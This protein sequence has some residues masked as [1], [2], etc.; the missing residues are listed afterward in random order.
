MIF[1]L[2]NIMKNALDLTEAK[3]KFYTPNLNQ[4]IPRCW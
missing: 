4:T 1:N 3:Q 2:D